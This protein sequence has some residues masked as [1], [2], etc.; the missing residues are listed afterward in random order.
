MRISWR[1][2]QKDEDF[3][4]Y[5]ASFGHSRASDRHT[6]WVCFRTSCSLT[7]SAFSR[8]GGRMARLSLFALRQAPHPGGGACPSATN[9]SFLGLAFETSLISLDH[10]ASFRSIQITHRSCCGGFVFAFSLFEFM[11]PE[12]LREALRSTARD[13]RGGF[14]STNAGCLQLWS[15]ALAAS[16]TASESKGKNRAIPWQKW[17]CF[18]ILSQPSTTQVLRA[19]LRTTARDARGGFVYAFSRSPRHLQ[20]PA[21]PIR[22]AAPTC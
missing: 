11:P 12:I 19:A 15:R 5:L 20:T 9:S 1:P 14:V 18:L 13:A 21:A 2:F 6:E 8:G 7:S 17:V 16:V 22:G 10:L 3:R 4:D